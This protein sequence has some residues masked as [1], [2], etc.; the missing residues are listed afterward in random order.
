MSELISGNR[1]LTDAE[2]AIAVNKAASGFQKMG[3]KAGDCVALMMRNDFPFIIASIAAGQLGAYVTPVNW[4]YTPAETKYILNDCG[5]RFLVVHTDLLPQIEGSVHADMT[6][7]V[8]ETPAEIAAAYKISD[9]PVSLPES[10]LKWDLWLEEQD[11]NGVEEKLAPASMIYT[12]G[13]TGHPK[14]V[15][16]HPPTAETIVRRL[17]SVI[18]G[19]GLDPQLGYVVLMNGPMYH[20]APNGYGIHACKNGGKII[21]EAKFDPEEM[22]QLIEQHKV[23]HMH[24]VP[25]MF[26]RLLKLPENIRN[27]YDVSSLQFIVHGAAPCPAEIKKAMIDWWGPVI[28]E[29]Y[30]GTETGLISVLNSADALTR[31]G[32][33][34]KQ[35]IRREVRVFGDDGQELEPNEIGDIYVDVPEGSDFTYHG[36]DQKRTDISHEGMVTLGDMG[37]KD[38]EGFIYLCDRRNDMVI[39]G[40]V[41]IYPAEI[42]LALSQMP[43]VKDCAVF[44]I[45]HEDFGETLC[46]YVELEDGETADPFDIQGFLKDKLASYKIPRIIKFSKNLPREDSGKIFKRKLRAPYWE[47]SGRKI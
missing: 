6:V 4:H 13:T 18:A 24:I 36:N 16:R 40:G 5:A 10:Y 11:P 21:F 15:K 8:V 45:P 42:E 9:L 29:Y 25:T 39:S 20:T 7:M 46:S 41:N 47:E 14:G 32:T 17:E 27:K 23:T 22:L 3:V 2:M 1:V 34:G 37:Y 35:M 38:E 44:G 26:S 31:P 19:F 43:I 28:N 30:G 12:S 33:V